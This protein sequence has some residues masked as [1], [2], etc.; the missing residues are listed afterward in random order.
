[1]WKRMSLRTDPWL[2]KVGVTHALSSS[3]SGPVERSC[4]VWGMGPVVG[5]FYACHYKEITK[6]GGPSTERLAEVLHPRKSRKSLENLS[7]TDSSTQ[8]HS[9]Q[10]KQERHPPLPQDLFI[11][12]LWCLSAYIYFVCVWCQWRPEE[13]VLSPASGVTDGCDPSLSAWNWISIMS[14][15]SKWS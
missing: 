7:A 5:C 11:L 14:K 15:S 8:K 12:Y 2:E 10:N 3:L 6:V 4:R 9:F 1:M 13:G